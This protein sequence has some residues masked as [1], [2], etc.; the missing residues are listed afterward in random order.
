MSCLTDRNL[1][2][3]ISAYI[4]CMAFWAVVSLLSGVV[5]VLISRANTD[6][7]TF[8]GAWALCVACGAVA[9][10]AAAFWWMVYKEVAGYL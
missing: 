2:A 7:L 1:R 6:V 3:A 10:A 4:G 5:I 9:F 8:V